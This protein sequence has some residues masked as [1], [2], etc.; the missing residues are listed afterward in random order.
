MGHQPERGMA[1][2]SKPSQVIFRFQNRCMWAGEPSLPICSLRCYINL[3]SLSLSLINLHCRIILPHLPL[4]CVPLS[5]HS[6]LFPFA[7]VF[8]ELFFRLTSL[9]PGQPHGT[10]FGIY[11]LQTLSQDQFVREKFQSKNFWVPLHIF[12]ASS[13]Q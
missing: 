8:S 2:I 5:C 6:S 13:P 4:L 9:S 10:C 11:E 3:L 1:E 12:I 7:I